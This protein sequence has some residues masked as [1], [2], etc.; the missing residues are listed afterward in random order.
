[1]GL[2]DDLLNVA[3]NSMAGYVAMGAEQ[4]DVIQYTKQIEAIY[5]ERGILD[6][7]SV[8]ALDATLDVL[9]S[10]GAE[11][12]RDSILGKYYSF[13]MEKEETRR[14]PLSTN[15]CS[16]GCVVDRAQCEECYALMKRARDALVLVNDAD[17][18]NKQVALLRGKK[19]KQECDFCGAPMLDEE[20]VCDYCGTRRS[21]SNVLK[22]QKNAY[23]EIPSAIANAAQA[24]H[25]YRM[26]HITQTEEYVFRG[27][28]LAGELHI[29]AVCYSANADMMVMKESLKWL[30]SPE[31]VR[32]MKQ[33]IIAMKK[34]M[35]ESDV[36]QAAQKTNLPIDVYLRGYMDGKVGNLATLV[37]E[38]NMQADAQKRKEEKEKRNQ[39]WE[40]L[41]KR[42]EQSKKEIDEIIYKQ[43]LA[44]ASRPVGYVGGSSSSSCCGNCRYYLMGD[45][46]CGKNEFRH[47]R[48]A[49]DYCGEY[50]SM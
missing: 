45:N 7:N 39:Q 32:K 27:M 34:P 21:A 14:S 38:E 22:L 15:M 35:S 36:Y 20:E 11:G 46:K 9:R 23:G 5:A 19:Q 48:G 18:Y 28:M 50:W 4:S 8:E 10:L 17:A 47:P 42:A 41:R 31:G 30:S 26:F 44:R 3:T 37:L 13:I 12:K 25:E 43:Q 40:E 24:I 16:A 1:M 49:S 33:N 6:P 2:F 29:K